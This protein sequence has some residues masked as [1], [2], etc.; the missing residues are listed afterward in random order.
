MLLGVDQ[1]RPTEA[2]N[3]AR[4]NSIVSA[5]SGSGVWTEP[6][7]VD[8]VAY[9]IMDGHHRY[10]AAQK[11]GLK[12]VPAV[13]VSYDDDRVHLEAWRC[14]EC[15]TPERVREVAR[16]GILLPEKSTRHMI[17]FA[18]PSCRVA[19]D[20]LKSLDSYGREVD[21]ANPLP[22]R[23]QLLRPCYLQIGRNIGITT[24]AAAN[25]D[26]ET[27]ETQVPHTHLRRMLQV[28]PAL[29]A[30]LP[31][32]SGRIALGEVAHAPFF[33]KTSGLMLLPPTLLADPAALAI[34][35]RW[36]LEASHAKN[37]S[38]LDAR[39]LTAILRHGAAILGAAPEPARD[40]LLDIM[41]TEVGR[42]LL[43][44]QARRPSAALLAWQANKI[45]GAP[46]PTP[47]SE[48][49]PLLTLEAP[50]ERLL[51]SGGDSRLALDPTGF[52]KY[53][54]PPRPRPEA[55]HFSSSTASAISDYGFMYCDILRRDLLTSALQDGANESDLARRAADATGRA[56]CGLLTLAEGVA[57]VAIT[58]SGTDVE[59]LTLMLALA[60]AGE[61]RLT[62][63][64]ISPEETGR[65]VKYAAAGRYFDDV[66][67]TGAPIRKDTAVWPEATIEVREIAIRGADGAPR[68]IEELDHEFVRCGAEALAAG[69]HVLA[70]ILAS[71]KTGLSAPSNRAI[72]AL[73]R[74]APD[75]VDVAVDACQMRTSFADVSALVERGWMVQIS[76][77]KFLTGP[78]FC[79]A[80]I[81]PIHLRARVDRVAALLSAA[82]GIGRAESW[83]SWWSDRLPLNESLAAPSFGP[84]FRWLPAILEAQLFASLPRE[85]RRWAFEQFRNAIMKRLSNSRWL[86]PIDLEQAAN[87]GSDDL[88]RL[89]IVSF[90]VLGQ[91][92]DG[93]LSPLDEPCC[94]AIFELLNV[95]AVDRL[96]KLSG[97]E[98]A[99]AAQPS[100]IGQ[101]VALM[102]PQDPIA[103]LRM[104][105]GARF[106]SI[107]GY[108]GAGSIEAALQSEISD[109]LRAIGK[110]ELLASRWWRLAQP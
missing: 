64:L 97:A 38:A 9:A 71:S 74:L 87:D 15:Y 45:E 50:I 73:V 89:S 2:T 10:S 23:A 88:S 40:L 67:A 102:G 5:L 37:H 7:L 39:W 77:S 54:V 98:R 31:A 90:E 61:R 80:L 35:A 16:S 46:S 43:A 51:I 110:L 85:F 53:G 107:V 70:H 32:A 86:R 95:N 6:L 22:T 57:D 48:E 24:P 108:A 42:E 79:G 62:N 83:T 44:D 105:L 41:P 14:G 27:A 19:L 66:A 8:A 28:D 56:L 30:L 13:L 92:Q 11:I 103:V 72:E 47:Q 33:L 59:L 29:A 63:L 75:R 94:R 3:S 96:G 55:V 65:G 104:V 1:I 34:A 49:Y 52:N 4:V 36:G 69:G 101:P 21:P 60:G 91:R 106:F 100:H 26:V 12:T 109:A 99:L 20:E 68:A 78:P 84:V 58:P 25:T 18:L 17:D 76:G 81:A 93:S 82:P